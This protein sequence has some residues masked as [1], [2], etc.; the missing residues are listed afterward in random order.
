MWR[1]GTW[2]P[3]IRGR[4]VLGCFYAGLGDLGLQLR[5]AEARRILLDSL[6]V[7]GCKP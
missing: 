1:R 6:G 3:K 5:G 7:E 4:K 2:A